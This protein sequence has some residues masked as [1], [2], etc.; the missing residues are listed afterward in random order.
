M[1]VCA[2][3]AAIP[4]PTSVE[5]VKATLATSGCSTRRCPHTDP[6]PATTFTTPAGRPASTAIFSSSSAVS[7]V[8]SAGFSTT[9]LPAARAGA[10]FQDAITS[11][12]FQGTII[13][14]TPRGSRKVMSTPPATGMVSPVS[15]CGAAA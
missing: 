14:T 6:G 7:G 11:G 12:K 2:A 1:I 15:R 10:T 4:R 13:P 8:S 5:P 3:A 9:V